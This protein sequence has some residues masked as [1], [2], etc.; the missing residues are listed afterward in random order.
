[1][2]EI[3]DL[4]FV[5]DSTDVRGA[6]TD[7]RAMTEAGARAETQ[8]E[9]LARAN[10][11]LA[12]DARGTAAAHRLLAGAIGG[13]SVAA[14]AAKVGQLADSYTAYTNS[15][16]VAGLEGRA[17]AQTQ[18]LLFAS[19]QKAGAPLEALGTLYG[20]AAMS[21]RDLGASQSE[22]L[23]FTDLVATSLKVG[24]KSAT[25]SS[26]ALLQLSQVLGGA[27]VQAEEYNSLIDGL[28]PLLVAVASGSDKWGGSVSRLTQDVKASKVSSAEFFAAALRGKTVLDD[29]AEKT[30]PTLAQSFTRLNNAVGRYIGQANEA[31]S[32]TTKIAQG[33]DL[34]STNLDK[35]VPVLGVA[36][37][38]VGLR[39]AAAGAQFVATEVQRAAA[40]GASI[41]AE[42]AAALSA[43][44]LNVAR[45]AGQAQQL[46]LT[47]AAIASSRAEM[48]ARLNAANAII[49]SNQGV[50]AGTAAV[51]AA[52]RARSVALAELAVLGRQAA[53]VNAQIT[54]TSVAAAAAQTELAA[55][56][57][58]ATASMAGFRAA[59]SGLLALLGGPWGVALLAAAAGAWALQRAL[60]ASDRA[61]EELKG[62]LG[63]ARGALDAYEQAAMDAATAS[64]KGAEKAKAHA[65]Q[66]RNE[67]AAAVQAARA[68]R[69]K[70]LAE[71]ESADRAAEQ[72]R[73]EATKRIQIAGFA[74]MGGGDPIGLALAGTAP[75]ALA[76]NRATQAKTRAKVATE[77]AAEAERRY[78]RILSQSASAATVSAVSTDKATKAKRGAKEEADDFIQALRDEVEEAGKTE[79][80]LR[81]LEIARAVAAAP[82][83]GQKATI[84]Q[85][86][87]E[88][89][90]ALTTAAA[91]E[92]LA[93]LKAANS[94]RTM[95][96]AQKVRS[97]NAELLG[98][99]AAGEGGAISVVGESLRQAVENAERMAQ[100]LD[101]VRGEIVNIKD[102]I[103]EDVGLLNLNRD[104]DA[105]Q[106][107][108]A[109]ATQAAQNI[110][111]AFGVTGE[112]IGTALT[113]LSNYRTAKAALS[114]QVAKGEKTEAEA[115]AAL[116][117]VRVRGYGDMA[118]AAKSYFKEG[119]TGYRALQVAE[120][121]FRTV[122]TLNTIQAM[123]LDTTYTAT[124]VANSATRASADGA[125]AYAK[126]LASLPFPFNLAAGATVLAAL[127]AVGV[128]VAGGGGG[129]AKPS[130]SDQRQQSQGA[131]T[132]LGD[133]AAKSESLERSLQIAMRNT[134]QDLEYSSQ[135][136]RSLRSIDNN[137]SSLAAAVARSVG[138]SAGFSTEGLGLGSSFK[139]SGIG[140]VLG[141]APVLGGFLSSLFGT[142]TKVTLSDFGLSFADQSI[143]DILANGVDASTYQDVTTTKKKKFLGLTTSTKTS[144]SRIA[145]AVDGDV[146]AEL[147]R[148][149][150]SLRDGVLA[151]ASVLGV[152][153]AQA[154]LDALRLTLGD[155]SLKDLKGDE[156]EQALSAVFGKA[157]DQMAEAVLPA[158]TKFQQVGEGAFETITR[159]ARDYQVVDV[160]LRSIGKSFALVGVSSIEARERLI[161]LVGGLDALQEGTAFFAENFLSEAERIAPLQ[162]AVTAE[163]KRL[164]LESIS[165]KEQFKQAV[166]GLDV[167]TEAGAELYAALIALAPAF[168]KVS[169]YMEEAADTAAE[170]ARR[171]ADQLVNDARDVVQ[172]AKSDLQ[173]SYQRES[174][175]LRSQID[176]LQG[177]SRS[178]RE[179][180]S[181]LSGQEVR[182]PAATRAA[183]ERAFREAA[184]GVRAN[185]GDRDAYS[186]LQSAGE[187]FV[188]ASRA[189]SGT[190]LDFNRDLAA[191]RREL[192]GAAASA[193]AQAG[194]AEQQLS[195][196]DALVAGQLEGNKAA[197]TTAQ[198][199]V[200]LL[201][202]QQQLVGAL[203]ARGGLEP[204]PSNDSIDVQRYLAGNPDLARNWNSGGSLRGVGASLE[205]AA[206]AHYRMTGQ[207]EIAAGLRKYAS[208]GS[209]EVRGSPVGDTVP[210]SF[211]A[212]G[213][214]HVNVTRAD[215]MAGVLRE[216]QALRQ[217]L[218]ALRAQQ[219]SQM[220]EANRHLGTT[221]NRLV[222]ATRGED[223]IYTKAAS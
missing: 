197:I 194:I 121:A 65:E 213:G 86:G 96:G 44:Q 53:S 159:L 1:M 163:L 10:R 168:A 150:A 193:D 177:I 15:L 143:A 133:A 118:R 106:I 203:A 74:A 30:A 90:A 82:L 146:T 56:S 81:A 95:S 60:T 57:R 87:R 105:L 185:P 41:N 117:N 101:A 104:L 32:A 211:M 24:G 157:A 137:M 8:A 28:R 73:N 3:A 36:I 181:R 131:G 69:E 188:A 42:R 176:A 208:G 182:S 173:A 116:T 55:A 20:R 169:D 63:G 70:S 174:S 91:W 160:T 97:E 152:E 37:G 21:A 158:V 112:A 221:A 222:R 29:M 206:L 166:L 210:V 19:A 124:S 38:Y 59:G 161:D 61:N 127:A 129:A 89:E 58:I 120:I 136:V 80:Q 178:M 75:T 109:Q 164:G 167:T 195:A 100:A 114:V 88:R 48:V 144:T 219:G 205:E 217:E 138:L 128:A 71:A 35:V 216:L 189:S 135:M 196:L 85:L 119:S 123:A 67:A 40:L 34:L 122:E 107:L 186:K 9:R 153:G 102:V 115:T 33:I 180:S 7:L 52:E 12:Q 199:M 140:K 14:A 111:D 156:L 200:A 45:T 25:E 79:K 77:A 113:T 110:A 68:L 31:S 66:L 26:G 78:E 183:A 72:A 175:A 43:A 214:E 50:L 209:F 62:S 223:H 134:N 191:V 22:L 190:V 132:V 49:A 187:A 54:A 204:T 162:Q 6:R 179:A 16:K 192:E 145:G 17:L 130:L 18:D 212:N 84:E 46:A 125:A 27:K 149:V 170:V 154:T 165:T 142:K 93:E 202:A 141:T 172:T 215:T 201:A 184:A 148:V 47:Q 92:R 4:E 198:A 155:V 83:E 207:Y 99:V 51:Q 126:T 139:T 64:G 23:T 147:Q 108:E 39:W 94:G 151:A 11:I 76:E 98:D 5:I 2:T 13:V 218:A 220:S 171:N 103:P